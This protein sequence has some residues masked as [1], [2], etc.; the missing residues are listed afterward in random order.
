MAD[1]SVLITRSELDEQKRLVSELQDRLINKEIQVLEGEKL[2][3][4]LHNT[5]LVMFS[6]LGGVWFL[7]RFLGS[8][9]IS[10]LDSFWFQELKG[11]IRVFCRVRPLLPDDDAGTDMIVSYP[12]STEALGRG[13][14]LV[15]TGR[16]MIFLFFE[17]FLYL[18]N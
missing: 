18:V 13:I 17:N 16:E 5:I 15:Q 7:Y 12:T 1:S 2:R 4:K 3:K 10:N 6:F 8:Y 11:N 9:D 14:E